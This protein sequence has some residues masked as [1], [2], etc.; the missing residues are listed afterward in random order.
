MYTSS[1]NGKTIA[2]TM[3][4]NAS[5]GRDDDRN[6]ATRPLGSMRP[7][8]TPVL[9][10]P[11]PRRSADQGEEDMLAGSI[12]GGADNSGNEDDV[13]HGGEE[14]LSAQ[15]ADPEADRLLLHR[16][17]QKW[18]AQQESSDK[19]G[20]IVGGVNFSKRTKQDFCLLLVA[21]AVAA[22]IAALFAADVVGP[23]S[24]TSAAATSSSMLNPPLVSG[25]GT[26]AQASRSSIAATTPSLQAPT[27]LRTR[28]P[29]TVP[30]RST[31][32]AVDPTPDPSPLPLTP[33]PISPGHG[34]Q[35]VQVGNDID[36]GNPFDESDISVAFSS[37]GAVVAIGAGGVGR[38]GHVRVYFYAGGG[39]QQRGSDLDGSTAGEEFGFSVSLSAD[40]TILAVGAILAD[41]V[42]GESSGQVHVFRWISNTSWQPLGSTLDGARAD[43]WF[44]YS[45]ALSDDGTILA[46]GGLGLFNDAGGT[47]AGHVRVVAWADTDWTQRGNDLVGSSPGDFL[48]PR[49][50]YHPTDP[51]WLVVAINFAI[52]VRDM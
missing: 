41:G 23:Q 49:F 43:D 27:K 22:L 39:W 18:I 8:S 37:N 31:G 14:L 32:T 50:L 19:A 33:A 6:S 20:C 36:V 16:E 4:P 34:A 3:D 45:I 38:A 17:F 26:S 35:W 29:T 9:L 15:M 12:S 5:T 30:A 47:S 51:S 11:H 10:S 24:L 1:R 44:G 28:N 42:N 25:F 48:G 21:L 40:G 46:V 13:D 52:K 2:E 7:S